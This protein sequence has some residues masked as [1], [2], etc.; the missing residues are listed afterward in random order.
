MS[1]FSGM[2]LSS[3]FCTNE[4]RVS[5]MRLIGIHIDQNKIHPFVRKSLKDEWY[6]FYGG[7]SY[8]PHKEYI[9]S[10][11]EEC[12]LDLYDISSISKINTALN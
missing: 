5:S 7:I 12:I 2:G 10:W 3:P 4:N 11:D 9:E 6:P 1:Y 8:P